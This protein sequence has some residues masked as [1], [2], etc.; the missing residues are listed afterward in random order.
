[1][2]DIIAIYHF[3]TCKYLFCDAVGDASEDRERVRR[4]GSRQKEKRDRG[5]PAEHWNFTR[6]AFRYMIQN[7][8]LSVHVH[9]VCVRYIFVNVHGT[10]LNEM[11]KGITRSLYN[12]I[13]FLYFTQ[14]PLELRPIGLPSTLVK[15]KKKK[16]TISILCFFTHLSWTLLLL[17]VIS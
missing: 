17:Y 16:Y 13:I 5:S 15:K 14:Q 12:S 11:I 9:N 10:C 4:L 1:M 3:I 8:Q 2:L 6:T 7:I